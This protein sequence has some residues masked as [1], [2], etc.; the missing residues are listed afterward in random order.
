MTVRTWSDFATHTVLHNM[1]EGIIFVAVIVFLFMA[2]WR[3]TLIV[4]LV[5]PLAF[6]VCLYLPQIKG[7]VGQS[8]IYGRY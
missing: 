8:F 1:F 3:T 7:N 4:S 2:D 5:I 6:V